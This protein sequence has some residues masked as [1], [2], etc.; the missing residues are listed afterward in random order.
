MAGEKLY[1]ANWVL[2]GL[3]GKTLK[4]GET[5]R[6]S[7]EEAEPYLGGVLSLVKSD[8]EQEPSGGQENGGNSKGK[9]KN[10]SK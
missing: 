8:E 6:L 3:N 10:Q 9:G 2:Q 4:P 5:I 7:P 1:R